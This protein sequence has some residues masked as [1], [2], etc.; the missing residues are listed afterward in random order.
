MISNYHAAEPTPEDGVLMIHQQPRLDAAT[1]KMLAE[2]AK[3]SRKT[4]D[5]LLREMIK[6]NYE[7]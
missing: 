7:R 6:D 2:L 3:D 5:S 1:L 4:P